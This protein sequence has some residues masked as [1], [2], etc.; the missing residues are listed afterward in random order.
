[1]KP[2]SCKQKGRKFQ[3]QIVQSIKETFPVLR[4]N[5]VKSTSMGCGGEDVVMSPLAESI[6]PYSVE[7]KNVE[8][9]NVYAA[10]EQAATNAPRKKTPILAMRR[11]R[12]KAYAVIQWDHFMEL[13]KRSHQQHEVVEVE[14]GEQTKHEVAESAAGKRERDDDGETQQCLRH[15]QF[16]RL[17]Q[18]L[19]QICE[20]VN[21]M[22]QDV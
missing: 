17:G 2:Q 4:D 15:T 3:Q 14:H 9:L 12:T 8:K 21:E 10:L 22:K 19:K 11:N 5:D 18:S 13:A 16:A 1:M 6:F 7:C 20:I